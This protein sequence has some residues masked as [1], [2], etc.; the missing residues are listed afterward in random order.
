MLKGKTALVT[1]SVI[2]IGNATARARGEGCNIMMCGLGTPEDI[3][4]SRAAI[5]ADFG[6]E[7]K[8]HDADLADRVRRKTW[9]SRQRINS[10]RLIFS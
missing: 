6:V 10:G 9:R 2:G 5:A 4:A 3:E 1:G 8:Y 7:V